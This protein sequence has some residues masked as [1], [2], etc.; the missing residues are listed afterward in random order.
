MCLSINHLHVDMCKYTEIC[1]LHIKR[2]Q[3]VIVLVAIPFVPL[4]KI[5]QSPILCLAE[6]SIPLSTHVKC[7]NSSLIGLKRF[8]NSFMDC[9]NETKK[10]LI[11]KQSYQFPKHK[12]LSAGFQ[13]QKA[14]VATVCSLT[15]G[16]YCLHKRHILSH[17]KC[18]QL[19]RALLQFPSYTN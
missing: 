14:F 6:L 7:I 2:R 18:C 10:L 13:W 17:T 12:D 9:V 4:R 3:Y 15:Y 16:N 1:V 5:F 11:C 8:V 19:K